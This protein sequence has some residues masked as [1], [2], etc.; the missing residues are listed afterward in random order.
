MAQLDARGWKYER[1]G[2][3]LIVQ[4]NGRASDDITRT[5]ADANIYLSELTPIARSLE[6]VFMELTEDAP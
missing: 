1:D 2:D 4:A 5:L 6:D 3:A